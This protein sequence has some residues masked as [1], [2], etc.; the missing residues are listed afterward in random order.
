MIQ[1]PK[2]IPHKNEPVTQGQR[3]ADRPAPAKQPGF[4][5]RNIINP[6]KKPN[7]ALRLIPLGGLEEI[8]K[9][10][11]AIEYGGDIILIDL[12]FQFPDEDMPGIDYVIPD[13]S[14]LEKNRQKIR[15]CLITHGHMDH[16]GAIPYIIKKIG[17]PPIFGTRLTIGLIKQRLEEFRLDKYVKLSTITS[18]DTLKLGCFKISFFRVNHNIPDGVGIAIETPLGIIIHTGDFKFDDHPV[19][20]K[21]TEFK[22]IKALGKKGV[23]LLASDSTNAENPGKSM[24]EKIIGESIDQIFAHAQG[25]IIFTTFSSLTS[26][27]QQVINSSE[28]YNRRVAISGLSMEKTIEVAIRLK[29]LRF[30]K[31]LF[32]KIGQVK[33]LPDKNA[34]ILSTGSQGQE[35]SALA[36]MTR[37]EHRQIQIKKGDTI[38]LSS[39]PIPGNERAVHNIMNRL[40]DAGAEVIYKKN[41]DIHTSGHGNQE[42]LKKMLQMTKPKFF[43]PIHGEHYMQIQHKKLAL[44]SGIPEKNIFMMDNGGILEISRTG[45]AKIANEK[46]PAEYIMVDGLGIGDV[47]N[48]VLRDRQVL[49]KDGMVV[50]I[51][52]IDKERKLVNKPDIISRGF[53]YMKSSE[54]LMKETKDKVAKI[55]KNYTARQGREINW[56][57]LR[58]RIRD[59]VGQFLFNKTE[60]RPMILPVVIEV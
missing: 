56:S 21:P 7:P 1:K 30:P 11:L 17:N 26:R 33:N 50:V 23:L 55:V 47:G 29:Y 3:N 4:K 41:L 40:V 20:D 18:N 58:S 24:S 43:L 12:G 48:V 51:A 16:T 14:Y 53:V 6:K 15:G 8:G 38:V 54:Q 35:M 37:G 10:C 13:T 27:I 42:D 5:L 44:E 22:K 32:V 46:A 31:N 49:S 39:S 2:L 36:R 52:A 59:D 19:D 57:P 45:E 34:I 25:R 60:R 28:K 9:N